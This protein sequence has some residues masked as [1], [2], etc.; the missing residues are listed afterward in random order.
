MAEPTWTMVP[1]SRSLGHSLQSRLHPPHA[2]VVGD[3][4]RAAELVR[5]DVV[6]EREHRRHGDVDP[7]VDRA[8]RLLGGGGGGLDGVRVRHVGW[9]DQGLAAGALHLPAG[10]LEAGAVASDQGEAG[11]GSGEAAHRRAADAARGAGDDDD[12]GHA[13]ITTR[14]PGDTAPCVRRPTIPRRSVAAA[15]TRAA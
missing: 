5:L 2:A 7:D 3:V 10:G 12:F 1:R 13:R 6:E 11:I 8:E 4:G 9:Q 15:G 14:R